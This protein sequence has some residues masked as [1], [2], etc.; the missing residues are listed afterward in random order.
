MIGTRLNPEGK[1]SVAPD[2]GSFNGSVGMEDAE[3]VMGGIISPILVR[4]CRVPGRE[5]GLSLAPVLYRPAE[6]AGV[7]R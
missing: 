1:A 3:M 7:T 6:Q 4:F 5:T 2:H